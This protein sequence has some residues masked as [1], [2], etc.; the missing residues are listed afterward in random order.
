[1]GDSGIRM[2]EWLEGIN[3]NEATSAQPKQCLSFSCFLFPVGLLFK[4]NKISADNLCIHTKHNFPSCA[5]PA[6]LQFKRQIR[7]FF[8]MAM[9]GCI[10]SSKIGKGE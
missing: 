1:M 2:M 6:A 8:C 3:N 4:C 5:L 10:C 9:N 7:T